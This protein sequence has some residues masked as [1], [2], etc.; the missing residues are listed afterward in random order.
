MVKGEIPTRE[1]ILALPKVDLH[2]HLD[3]SMRVETICELASE[4]KV[5]LPTTDEK[6]L[7]K[8]LLCGRN[9]G[10]LEE[11]LKAFDLTLMV[12]QEREGLSR[13]AYDLAC[14]AADENVWYLEVRFSPILHQKNGMRL[15]EIVDAVRE[16][17]KKAEK[18]KKEALEELKWRNK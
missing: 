1:M 15:S 7:R 9:A 2:C 4:L 6:E 12:L 14:D 8:I 17:L 18:E 5:Q 3:G 11:F 13:A 16:G 10:T